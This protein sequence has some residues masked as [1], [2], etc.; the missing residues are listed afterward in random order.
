MKNSMAA[1]WKE[2][3][4]YCICTMEN[5]E[6]RCFGKYCLL[7]TIKWCGDDVNSD[8]QES[9]AVFSYELLSKV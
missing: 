9:E 1:S 3:T 7:Q 2:M 5:M 6:G 4:V 8:N